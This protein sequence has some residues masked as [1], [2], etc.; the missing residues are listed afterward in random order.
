MQLKTKDV[1][2]SLLRKG[3]SQS[4]GDHKFFYLVVNGKISSI[5]TKIS[6]GE[7]TI[8]DGLRSAMARQLKLTNSEFL[9]LVR[10]TLAHE[11]YVNL[12]VQRG[13]LDQT[14]IQTIATKQAT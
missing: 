8:H 1:A 3:F 2:D 4:G 6:H 7:K 11:P 14:L 13:H 5:H 10:C 9:E 12:L